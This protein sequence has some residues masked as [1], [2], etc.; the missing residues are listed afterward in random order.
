MIQ[1]RIV[2][3]FKIGQEVYHVYTTYESIKVNVGCNTCN[4]TGIVTINRKDFTCPN[5]HGE[6]KEKIRNY[7]YKIDTFPCS[8]L[9]IGKIETVQYGI[10]PTQKDYIEYMCKE[11]GIDS[12]TCYY[13]PKLFASKEEAE[14][15]CKTHFP[16][17]QSYTNKGIDINETYEYK[18][19]NEG[20]N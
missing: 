14:N 15:F 7:K 11:T 3:K 2:P 4:S 10:R 12:G 18:Y 17:S 20:E 19:V 13:E 8:V 6:T 9:T 1:K 16:S 5:C